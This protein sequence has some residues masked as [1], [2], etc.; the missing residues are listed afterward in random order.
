MDYTQFHS[1]Q[2]TSPI[3]QA[4]P[5]VTLIEHLRDVHLH[6]ARALNIQTHS[7]IWPENNFVGDI[8]FKPLRLQPWIEFPRLQEEIW[9]NL[10]GVSTFVH[11]GLFD[12]GIFLQ[13]SAE[14]INLSPIMSETGLKI[15]Q[16]RT[17]EDFL[18]Q[19]VVFMNQDATLQNTFRLRGHLMLDRPHKDCVAI[20][21]M[22]FEEPCYATS[23][24]PPYCLTLPELV[25][26]LR[27][28]ETSDILGKEPSTYEEHSTAMV[29][30]AII[31]LFSRMISAGTQHGY[32]CTGEAF[33]FVHI[34]TIDPGVVEYYLCVPGQDVAAHGYDADSTWVRRTA[35]GQVLAFTLQSLL[36]ARPSH[37]WHDTAF[38]SLQLSHEDYSSLMPQTP[39]NIRLRPPAKYL[40][41]N[42]FWGRFW[43][44]LL[45][46]NLHTD[47]GDLGQ[48]GSQNTDLQ[49]RPYCTMA[50]LRGT[51]EKDYLDLDCPNA[52]DHGI[53]RHSINSQEIT[54]RLS[55]QL[56][57]SR[58]EGFQQLHVIGRTC[59]L[60]KAVLLSHGYTVL[61]KATTAR[62][63]RRIKGEARN[64]RDLI[65]LQGSK[66]PVCLGMFEPKLPYWYHGSQMRYMLVLSWSGIRLDHEVSPGLRHFIEMQLEELQSILQEHGVIQ[67]DA[68][69][70]N[71]LWNSAS[72]SLVMIDLEDMKW[73]Q[74]TVQGSDPCDGAGIDAIREDLR[75]TQTGPEAS[76][77]TMAKNLR[78]WHS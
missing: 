27:A 71:V 43:G 72:H 1:L 62:Q 42:S 13:S 24:I 37:E 56:L 30:H 10:M 52:S 12:Q 53:E 49:E 14:A 46:S 63:S 64:Y 35:L 31:R 45:Q 59:Y 6:F 78:L 5:A 54:D 28:I 23:A 73:L 29:V 70:R 34:S 69:Y 15:F 33:V 36:V 8:R 65:A 16:A 41:Q 40:Y 57:E 7:V 61:I 75:K 58:Y 32:I 77:E 39:D 19:I 38:R 22:G 48:A 44:N 47:N 21:T 67:R 3:L 55:A 68:A 50:C 2:F 51:S 4:L 74:G 17:M 11:S 20:S 66:I 25:A 18:K 76:F 26:G 9:T 60:I